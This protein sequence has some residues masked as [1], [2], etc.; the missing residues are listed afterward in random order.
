MGNCSAWEMRNKIV[1]SKEPLDEEFKEKF[2]KAMSAERLLECN[3]CIYK[4]EDRCS[5]CGCDLIKRTSNPMA[6]CGIKN[7]LP[8]WLPFLNANDA[9]KVH[10]R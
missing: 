7:T 1:K 9:R 10:P 8:K 5:E 3:T 6:A 2:I 4:K